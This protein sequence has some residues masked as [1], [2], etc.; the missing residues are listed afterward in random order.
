MVALLERLDGNGFGGCFLR[1]LWHGRN[2]GIFGRNGTLSGR[3]AHR[4]FLQRMWL[5]RRLQCGGWL[6]RCDPERVWPLEQEISPEPQG[7]APDG[8][9]AEKSDDRDD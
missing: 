9:R 7:Q 2:V 3:A 1:G 6:P 8:Q 5:F 4:I